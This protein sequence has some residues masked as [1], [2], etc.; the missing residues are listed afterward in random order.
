MQPSAPTDDNLNPPPASTDTTTDD[1]TSVAPLE[2]AQ[3]MK[4]TANV[5][6]AEIE[7]AKVAKTKAQNAQVKKFATHMISE[8]TKSKQKGM[9]LSKKA[10]LDP[11]DSELGTQL[12]TKA[13]RMLESLEAADKTAFDS[14]YMQAQVQQHQEVLNLLDQQLI[15]NAKNEDLKQELQA[16]REMVSKHLTQAQEIQQQLP[17]TTASA[18]TP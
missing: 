1:T 7:Q 13:T 18:A 4:I 2:D 14:A 11:A 15:P 8:H 10:D 17:T 6:T 5:D 3:I 9:R 16:T 12:E